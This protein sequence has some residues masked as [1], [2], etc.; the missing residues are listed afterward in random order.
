MVDEK[1]RACSTYGKDE[2]R[3]KGRNHLRNLGVDWR[4][5]K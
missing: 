1:G 4:I 5:L 2:K 3:L